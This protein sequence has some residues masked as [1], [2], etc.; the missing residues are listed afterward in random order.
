MA[1]LSSIVDQFRGETR[2]PAGLV[3]LC[4]LDGQERL[5]RL[6]V[7]SGECK[8]SRRLVMRITLATT[9]LLIVSSSFSLY[10]CRYSQPTQAQQGTKSNP[11]NNWQLQLPQYRNGQDI[12]RQISNNVERRIGEIEKV[13]IDA[14]P[15]N[16]NIPEHGGGNALQGRRQDTSDSEARRDEHH[17]VHNNPEDWIVGRE[18]QVE[19]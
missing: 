15:L 1:M 14:L 5:E 6:H 11:L 13:N 10:P 3:G 12:Y 7:L 9:T 18:T 2:F 17:H 16:L 4:G 19:G 8:S